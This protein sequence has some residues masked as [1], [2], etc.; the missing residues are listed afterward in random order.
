MKN[1]YLKIIL[2]SII[3][4]TLFI[5]TFFLFVIPHF[6]DNMMLGKKEMIKELVNS[7]SSILYKYDS[8][9]SKG[10]ITK[11]EAQLIAIK[12]IQSLR[13][14]QENIDYFW[15]SDLNP[16]MIMHPYRKDLNNKDLNNYTDP[17]GKKIFVEFAKVVRENNEGYVDYKWQSKN[18]TSLIVQKLS[19]VKLFKPW[20][21]VIGTGIYVEDVEEE[22]SLLTSELTKISVVISLLIILL[23]IFIYQQSL[24]IEQKRLNVLSNLK[25]RN[26]ELLLS[27]SQILESEEKFKKLFNS[28]HDG[29]II[30][31]PNYFI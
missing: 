26:D 7:A 24:K 18:D 12:E 22:I 11:E 10:L 28:S 8:E 4:I 23:L 27:K 31:E 15:M 17:E 16:T 20:A 25:D 3:S 1:L 14:G 13:Y 9:Y 19:F 6:H 29:I 30:I 5:L 21:W 2:P